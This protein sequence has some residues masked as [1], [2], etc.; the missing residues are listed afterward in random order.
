MPHAIYLGSKIATS[1]RINDD[2]DT[3]AAKKTEEGQITPRSELVFSPRAHMPQPVRLPPV[4][5]NSADEYLH[6]PA[7]DRRSLSDIRCH[8]RH[9]SWDIALSLIFFALVINS[10]IL[11]VASA[12]FHN[13]NDEE[14]ASDLFAAHGLIRDKVGQAPAFLFALGLLASGQCA[15]ITVTLAGQTVSEG[16]LE[17]RTSPIVRR[18]VTRSIGLV[19]SVAV[20]ASVGREGL[21]TLL[22]ASQVTLSVVLPFVIFP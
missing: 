4:S 19:P 17:W 13:T 14:T 22:V 1:R 11:I 21:D 5:P 15:S 3:D 2:D 6:A 12:A 7:V 9:A 18:I 8:V 16:F 20:A 10:S